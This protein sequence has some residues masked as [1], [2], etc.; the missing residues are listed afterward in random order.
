LTAIIN[1]YYLELRYM[2]ILML[3]YGILYKFTLK[4]QIVHLI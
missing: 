1:Y 4:S 2:L 3:I